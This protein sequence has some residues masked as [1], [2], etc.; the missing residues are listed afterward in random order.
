MIPSPR[1]QGPY[2]QYLSVHL[3]GEAPVSQCGLHQVSVLTSIMYQSVS[4]N[5]D[6]PLGDSRDSHVFTAKGVEF[7]RNFLCPGVED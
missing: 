2:T 4:S 6:Y 3:P 5:P 7:S 1:D